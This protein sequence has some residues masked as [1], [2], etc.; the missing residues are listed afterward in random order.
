MKIGFTEIVLIF[1]VA[2]IVIGPDKLPFYAKKLGVG[3]RE[4]RKATDDMTKDIRESVV[5]P[6][7]EAQKPIREAMEPFEQLD[8]DVRNNFKETSDSLNNIGKA[9]KPEEAEK[10]PHEEPAA[11]AADERAEDRTADE[12]AEGRAA[13]ERAEDRTAYEYADESARKEAELPE[14]IFAD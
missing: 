6:L 11:R 10:R 3:L 13:D 8:R 9:K 14:D 2:L 1:I 7:E 12:R 5:E 4:F